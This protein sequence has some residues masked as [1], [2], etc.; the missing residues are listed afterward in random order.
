MGAC[1]GDRRETLGPLTSSQQHGDDVVQ[2]RSDMEHHCGHGGVLVVTRDRPADRGPHKDFPFYTNS[3]SSIQAESERHD[4]PWQRHTT[5]DNPLWIFC[6][7][8]ACKGPRRSSRAF[9]YTCPFE[10]LNVSDDRGLNLGGK[11]PG[12]SALTVRH[13]AKPTRPALPGNSATQR[14]SGPARLPPNRAV[15][16]ARS[17]QA[18]AGR[19]TQAAQRDVSRPFDD[20]SE[21]AAGRFEQRQVRWCLGTLTEPQRESPL[22]A[23]YQGYTYPE[24]ASLPGLALGTVRPACGTV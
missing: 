12:T 13:D 7:A 14:R 24:V 5:T 21:Q 20:V 22:L 16:R 23:Y 18:A 1:D 15:D 11:I 8:P 19:E 6:L 3:V 4:L 10:T 2:A 17:A 9:D